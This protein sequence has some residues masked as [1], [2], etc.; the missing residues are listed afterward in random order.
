[1]ELQIDINSINVGPESSLI[2]LQSSQ[3]NNR[4]LYMCTVRELCNLI[5]ELF[6]WIRELSNF[7]ESSPIQWKSPLIE[8]ENPSI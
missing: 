3:F 1:M 8:L 6:H 5:R 7:L 4:A 2:Q